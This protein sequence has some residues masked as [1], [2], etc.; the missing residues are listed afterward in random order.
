MRTKGLKDE[1]MMRAAGIYNRVYQEI[2]QE[3]QYY[4]AKNGIALALNYNSDKVDP[5]KPADVARMLNRPVVYAAN[6]D[7]TPRI[8]DDLIQRRRIVRPG[9]RPAPPPVA[10]QGVNGG[11]R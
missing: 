5:N 9:D 8:V 2:F 6:I 11:W 1:F 7:I 4:C 10:N 3:V